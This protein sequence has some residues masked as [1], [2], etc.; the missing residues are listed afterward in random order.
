MPRVIILTLSDPTA[1]PGGCDGCDCATETPRVPVLACA[2]ALSDAGAVPEPL[3]ACDDAAI[4][5]ALK[6][7][8][9]GEARLVVAAAD[10]AQLRAV[11]RRMVRILAPPP[12]KRP[13]ELPEGRTVFDLPP[14]GVLPLTPGIPELV[15]ALGLPTDAGAVAQAVL[16]ETVRRFDLLRNDGGS[17]TLHGTLIGGVTAE[18]RPGSWRGRIEVDDAILSGGE[19]PILACS[20]RNIGASDVDGLPLVTAARP[21]DGRVDV[22]VAVPVLKRRLIRTAS[23]HV[24]VRRA[25]GR[26]VSV[27]PRDSVYLVDDGVTAQLGRKRA[28]W[29]ERGAWAVYTLA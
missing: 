23:V 22:A 29:I 5:S 8:L 6:P 9:A 2:A 11:V 15:P 14:L 25:S 20:I 27:S 28:W 13:A 18:G 4:D 21:D 19:D 12:S 24:E 7:V 10:D 26:A 3:T 17:V 16:G 1:R